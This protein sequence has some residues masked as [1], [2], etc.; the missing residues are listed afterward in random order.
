MTPWNIISDIEFLYSSDF[1][2]IGYNKPK[3]R[4][5]PNHS[6]NNDFSEWYEKQLEKNK[7]VV[8]SRL[9]S[10]VVGIV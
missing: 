9:S 8:D 10:L 4:I 3:Y 1:R 2:N 6:R 5:K 7:K